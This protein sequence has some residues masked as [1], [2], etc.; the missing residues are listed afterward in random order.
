MR[1]V[2]ENLLVFGFQEVAD[3]TCAAEGVKNRVEVKG[4]DVV[5]EPGCDFGFAA[6]VAGGWEMVDYCRFSV[7]G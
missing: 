2:V 6:L 5:P 3:N 4:F 1:V 7:E